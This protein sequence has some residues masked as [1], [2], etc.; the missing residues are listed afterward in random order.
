MNTRDITAESF[1]QFPN[2]SL[3]KITKESLFE[4]IL[5]GIPGGF[6]GALSDWF[7]KMR[8]RLSFR[9]N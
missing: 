1:E 3:E 9:S 2:K 8:L 4:G 5:G 7:P 6:V